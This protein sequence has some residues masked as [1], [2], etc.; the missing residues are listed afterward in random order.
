MAKYSSENADM[1][2]AM[3]P[4]EEISKSLSSAESS[5]LENMRCFLKLRN[6]TFKRLACISDS[7]LSRV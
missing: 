6:V 3:K 5:S 7:D 1:K 4:H 2:S